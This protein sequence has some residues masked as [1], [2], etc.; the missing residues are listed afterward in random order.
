MLFSTL[1]TLVIVGEA[2]QRAPRGCWQLP[3]V[4]E[5]RPNPGF[6]EPTRRQVVD[7]ASRGW[8]ERLGR[9]HSS[10]RTG[11]GLTPLLSSF[12]TMMSSY[13]ESGPAPHPVA[14]MAS[15]WTHKTQFPSWSSSPVREFFSFFPFSSFSSLFFVTSFLAVSPHSF[16]LASLPLSCLLSLL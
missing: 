16:F 13:D 12:L 8:G 3:Q 9:A 15:R 4:G 1:W 5:K 2:R 6:P 7:D 11:R 14:T 10:L